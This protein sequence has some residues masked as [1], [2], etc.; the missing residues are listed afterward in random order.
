[1]F[2]ALKSKA[3]AD[4]ALFQRLRQCFRSAL[5]LRSVNITD[6]IVNNSHVAVL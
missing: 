6:S 1:L 2:K 4:R 5:S 3:R